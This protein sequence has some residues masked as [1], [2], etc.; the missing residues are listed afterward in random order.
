[1]ARLNHKIGNLQTSTPGE[2]TKRKEKGEKQ[3]R[4][5]EKEDRRDCRGKI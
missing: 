4:H 2:N 1:M 3:K 5:T